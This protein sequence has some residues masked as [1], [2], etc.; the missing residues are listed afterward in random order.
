MDKKTKKQI[1]DKINKRITRAEKA[2]G[3]D[4]ETKEIWRDQLKDLVPDTDMLTKSGLLRIGDNT[5]DLF[6]DA[7][8]QVLQKNLPQTVGQLR[9]EAEDRIDDLLRSDDWDEHERASIIANEVISKIRVVNILD[10]TDS[11]ALISDTISEWDS[12]VKSL[13]P[14]L[15]VNNRELYQ[16]ILDMDNQ[17][18]DLRDV[19]YSDLFYILQESRNIMES[20]YSYQSI[21]ASEDKS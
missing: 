8:L 21:K 20:Y 15:E 12:M 10:T 13:D 3:F 2:F 6:D 11:K 5:L 19:S 18:S 1:I 16:T 7:T 17:L 14:M 4:K 9:T